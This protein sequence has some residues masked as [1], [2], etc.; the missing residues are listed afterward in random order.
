MAVKRP[1]IPQQPRTPLPKGARRAQPVKFAEPADIVYN[2]PSR[3]RVKPITETELQRGK[4]VGGGRE[5]QSAVPPPIRAVRAR[6]S[7]LGRLKAEETDDLAEEIGWT[8]QIDPAPTTNPEKPRTLQL[9]YVRERGEP[10][11]TIRVRFRD[12]TPW[13]YYDVPP[14]VWKNLRRVKSPGRYINRVLNNFDYGRGDF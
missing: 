10:T 14:N 13:E 12:G 9:G 6:G 3:K 7:I 11:G 8:P 4:V 5:Q 2:P 1:K